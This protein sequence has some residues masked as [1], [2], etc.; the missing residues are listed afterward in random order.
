[1]NILNQNLDNL[2]GDLTFYIDIAYTI[3]ATSRDIDAKGS[4]NLDE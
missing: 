1:M 3:E 2:L 4:E